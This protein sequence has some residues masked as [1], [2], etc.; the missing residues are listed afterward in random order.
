MEVFKHRIHEDYNPG[1]K[2]IW[3]MKERAFHNLGFHP[4][5]KECKFCKHYACRCK[6]AHA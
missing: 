6:Y 2:E 3:R 5:I 4:K 1:D